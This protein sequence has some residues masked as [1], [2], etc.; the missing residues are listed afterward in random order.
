MSFAVP[1]GMTTV[2]GMRALAEDTGHIT[3]DT[4]QMKKA[5]DK[6]QAE[7]QRLNRKNKAQCKSKQ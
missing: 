1:V 2:A 4:E 7:Q 6:R 5:G 3:Q